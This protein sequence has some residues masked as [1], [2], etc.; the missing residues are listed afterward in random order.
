[1]VLSIGLVSCTPSASSIQTA[2]A[3]TQ[4]IESAVKQQTA[5]AIQAA[6]QTQETILEAT[7][8]SNANALSVSQT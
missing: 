4:A 7:E 3:G 8:T 6:T 5:E 1:M 2:I